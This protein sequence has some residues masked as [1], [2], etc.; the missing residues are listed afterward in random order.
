MNRSKMSAERL[1]KQFMFA[2][3]GSTHPLQPAAVPKGKCAPGLKGAALRKSGKMDKE[4]TVGG[5]CSQ[6]T[7]TPAEKGSQRLLPAW[8][9]PFCLRLGVTG[10]ST[11][12][13]HSLFRLWFLTFKTVS[14]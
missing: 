12:G 7:R 10:L 6:Q 11:S 2:I 8:S 5:L 3:A 9:R 4:P 13:N 1:I 14:H